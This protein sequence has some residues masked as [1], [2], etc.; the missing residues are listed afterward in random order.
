MLPSFRFEKL[1]RPSYD[2]NVSK[3]KD[4]GMKFRSIEEMFDDCV[5]YFTAQGYLSPLLVAQ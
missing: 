2:L 1:D 4:L 3:L 5:E